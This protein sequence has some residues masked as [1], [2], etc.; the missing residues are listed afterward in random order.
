M[1]EKKVMKHIAAIFL[2]LVLC[3][4]H[5]I[6]QSS[7]GSSSGTPA[8]ASGKTATLPRSVNKTASNMSDANGRPSAS[9]IATAKS[10]GKVW[11][12]TQSG[13]YHRSGRWYGKT[14]TGKFMTESEAKAAGYKEAKK[15]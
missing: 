11:V 12:N 7:T 2:L 15:D 1:I 5:A 14:K 13:V 4:F 3:Q 10:S 8:P 9:E 6:A